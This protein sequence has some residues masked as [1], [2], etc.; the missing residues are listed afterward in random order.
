NIFK[1]LMIVIALSVANNI[2]AAGISNYNNPNGNWW[3][4]LHHNDNNNNNSNSNNN[5]SNSNNNNSNSNNNNSNSN[6]NKNYNG[7]KNNNNSNSNNNNNNHG[8]NNN[9]GGCQGEVTSLTLVRGGTSSS[10]GTLY[11]WAEI[12]RDCGI[13]ILANVAC[14][15]R[16]RSVV[17]KLDG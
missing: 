14:T 7:N 9:N 12:D 2:S 6:N 10:I 3:W 8:N 5:N 1:T 11:D 15:G 17:F 13:N 16:V 4:W